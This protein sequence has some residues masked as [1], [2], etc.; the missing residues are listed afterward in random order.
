MKNT[1]LIIGSGPG[2]G[3]AT[4]QRF[5]REGYAIVLSSRNLKNL[6]AQSAKL[7]TY[8]IKATLE[9]ADANDSTQIDNLVARLAKETRLTVLYNAGVLRYDEAG[10]LKP[11]TLTDHSREQLESDININLTSA[12]VA[13]RA[14]EIGMSLQNEGSIF[15]TGGGFGINPSPDFLPISI[16][17]AGIRA[18][19][20][21]M[22]EPLKAKGIH[23]GTVTVSKLIDS[24]SQESRD[25]ADIFWDMESS[26]KEAWVWERV[27][28]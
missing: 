26:P 23:I 4:A 16:G 2:I 24:D 8:G 19:T 18:L 12:L 10:N 21:G 13:V 17:K 6:Q 5:A 14:A 25:V 7:S 9:V 22:F 3:L 27:Y 11:M 20:K 1:L 28:G 15:I